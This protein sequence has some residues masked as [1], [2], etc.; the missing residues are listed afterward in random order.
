[1][2]NIFF[3][4][5]RHVL[6]FALMLL[7]ASIATRAQATPCKNWSDTDYGVDMKSN[8][9]VSLR[10]RSETA[11]EW[12]NKYST[13]IPADV[14]DQAVIDKTLSDYDLNKGN[15]DCKNSLV[16][17]GRISPT[18]ILN[19]YAQNLYKFRGCEKGFVSKPTSA[20][21]GAFDT[22]TDPDSY[23]RLAFGNSIYKKS[24]GTILYA[25]SGTCATGNYCMDSALIKYKDAAGKD[26]TTRVPFN[27][28]YFQGFC[29]S[30]PGLEKYLLGVKAQLEGK[31]SA[32]TDFIATSDSVIGDPPGTNQDFDSLKMSFDS[33]ENVIVDSHV[34]TI[35]ST[36]ETYSVDANHSIA[37]TSDASGKIA[38]FTVTR[39]G[40][41]T[42]TTLDRNPSCHP[43]KEVTK[44]SNGK[45]LDYDY[46]AC[47]KW[48]GVSEHKHKTTFGERSVLTSL[49]ADSDGFGS[50]IANDFKTFIDGT[51]A[52]QE[53]TDAEESNW[54]DLRSS[55]IE[56]CAKN[57][58][59]IPQGDQ[60]NNSASGSGNRAL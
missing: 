37:F 27:S 26:Q 3:N 38:T 48:F 8:F 15:Q 51:K 57:T 30:E 28:A 17:D 39:G 50:L 45:F 31:Q 59:Y 55:V 7:F 14:I 29:N 6:S 16:K 18:A 36:P 25:N 11:D 1:M 10:E 22:W 46:E 42:V 54:S 33:K 40:R 32:C 49:Y 19:E 52:K 53:L 47:K 20:A 41:T 13:R 58:L 35:K 43:I 9:N 34:A 4:I 2:N 23:I 21:K 5:S 44:T 56:S 24:N 12:G 60:K